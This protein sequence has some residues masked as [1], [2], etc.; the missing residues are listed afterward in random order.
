MFTKNGLKNRCF[1][2]EKAKK[3]IESSFFNHQE[4]DVKTYPAENIIARYK[5]ADPDIDYE[6]YLL[7]LDPE[8]DK[9]VIE[10]VQ[11]EMSLLNGQWV[12]L[13]F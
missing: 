1:D 4:A 8:L 6:T 9:D 5:K 12:V 3:S 10:D 11:K 7:E 13:V 2:I